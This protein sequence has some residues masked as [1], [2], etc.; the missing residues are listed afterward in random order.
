LNDDRSLQKGLA[1]IKEWSL[2]LNLEEQ[3]IEKAE[4]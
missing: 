4:E 2:A 3:V 1:K